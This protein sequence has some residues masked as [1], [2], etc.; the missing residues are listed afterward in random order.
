MKANIYK[1]I[2]YIN[3][4]KLAYEFCVQLSKTKNIKQAK[5]FY[6]I[7]LKVEHVIE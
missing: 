3:I 4:D 6:H 1:T 2:I 7:Y 5:I